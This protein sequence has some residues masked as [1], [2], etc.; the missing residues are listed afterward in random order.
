MGGLDVQTEKL[1]AFSVEQYRELLQHTEKMEHVLEDCDHVRVIEHA[2]SLQR[3]QA[4]ASQQDEQLL[5]LLKLD[6]S[7]WENHDLYRQ[8]QRFVAGILE[9]NKLLLPK[10]RGIMAV[11]SAELDQLRSGRT[12]LA[13]Y[14]SSSTR[15]R[16]IRGVG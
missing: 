5:P 6:P 11:A 8:R 16:G 12:A 10:I 1:L 13:G 2:E 3:L 15:R 9:R 14:A 4:A 7:A